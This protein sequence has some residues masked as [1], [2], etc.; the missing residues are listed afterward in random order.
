M[1]IKIA[2]KAHSE[3]PYA[4]IR[5]FQG[6]FKSISKR[7]L[8]TLKSNITA[9][10]FVAPI[11]V[12]ANG[13]ATYCLDGH[14][15]LLA[16]AEL[17]AEGWTVPP[18]PVAVVEAETKKEARVRLLE[19]AS[20]FGDVSI[21]GL[22]EFLG[23][24]EMPDVSDKIRLLGT[25]TALT[26]QGVGWN[27]PRYEDAGS[28]GIG[29]LVGYSLASFWKDIS[30][31]SSPLSIYQLPLPIW[32]QNKIDM[33]GGK[34]SRT[35]LQEI[36]RVVATYMRPGDYFLESC[37]GWATF[38]SAA[39]AHGYSGDAVDIWGEAIEHSRRQIEAMP[40][41]GDVAVAEMDAM[42][43]T[44][45]DERFDVVYSNPPFMDQEAYSGKPNDIADSHVDRFIGKF[46]R[47]Q[48][49]NR[50]V[51]KT[52]GLCIITINDNRKGG[53]LVPL[54]G[55]VTAASEKAGFRLHDMVVAEVISQRLR[56]R[57]QEYKD[58]RTVKCHEYVLVFK[59]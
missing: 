35:N 6:T 57:K 56:M 4:S 45:P 37:C 29:D 21:V 59:K 31:N 43:L 53:R 50:R 14:Q 17:E 42:E 41:D 22:E 8:A 23:E 38:A 26:S 44:F 11:F 3:L 33:V 49:E 40:G 30:T 58:R 24:L 27:P 32:I 18:V 12:W 13:K 46:G 16:L 47:M 36:E 54:H 2:C 25:E 15:R 28:D 1:E 7:N 20:Q 19:I 39:K 9:D 48:E 5:P 34:Y 51:L 10:G 55:L 52:G